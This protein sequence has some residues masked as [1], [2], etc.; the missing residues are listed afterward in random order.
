MWSTGEKSIVYEKNPISFT[1]FLPCPNYRPA[2]LRRSV[3]WAQ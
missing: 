3:K 2:K 1:G